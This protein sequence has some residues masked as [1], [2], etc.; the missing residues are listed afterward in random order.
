MFPEM[1]RRLHPMLPREA[2]KN[3][4]LLWF[5]TLEMYEICFEHVLAF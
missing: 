5:L 2:E 4:L 1:C 3:F